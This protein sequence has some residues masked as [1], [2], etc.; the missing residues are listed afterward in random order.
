M[1][2]VGPTAS[3]EIPEIQEKVLR[4]LG[5]WMKIN[6]E[7]IYAT[8]PAKEMASSDTPWVR[9]TSKDNRLFAH[10][11]AVGA[12]NLKDPNNLIAREKEISNSAKILGAGKIPI[13]KDGE[14]LS[15]EIP[16]S[17]LVGPTVIEFIRKN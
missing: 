5:D 6:S 12:V 14:S 2:N 8:R 9:W 1:L 7:A 11:D 13:I 15:L 4:G 16:K 17:N 10:I 3:G